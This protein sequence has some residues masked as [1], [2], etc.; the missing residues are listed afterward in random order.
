MNCAKCNNSIVLQ[1]PDGT[2]TCCHDRNNPYVPPK[3]KKKMGQ[4]VTK[5]PEERKA[6]EK[7]WFI[8]NAEHRKEYSREYARKLRQDEKEL[9]LMFPKFS[10]VKKADMTKAQL[11][12][13]RKLLKKYRLKKKELE[14][15]L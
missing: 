5:T 14:E 15:R 9:R 7:Q 12:E 4:P 2:G 13:Y 6:K 11:Q 10:G 3:R 8:D 1:F